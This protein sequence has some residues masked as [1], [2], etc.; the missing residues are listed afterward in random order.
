MD[1]NRKINLKRTKKT[2]TETSMKQANR[3]TMPTLQCLLFIDLSQAGSKNIVCLF[4]NFSQIDIKILCAWLKHI[5]FLKHI[6]YKIQIAK[7]KAKDIETS[8]YIIDFII[9]LLLICIINKGSLNV[10][11]GPRG[12][13]RLRH[14]KIEDFS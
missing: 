6:L 9:M 12:P 13:D 5:L 10:Y 7:N 3:R 8:I 11:P 2:L 1:L 14:I 4:I